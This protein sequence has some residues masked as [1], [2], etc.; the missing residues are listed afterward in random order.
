M[1]TAFAGGDLA[2]GLI[3]GV[4]QMAQLSRVPRSLH[5]DTP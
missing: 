4:Q 2:R 3:A 1:Q 5:T